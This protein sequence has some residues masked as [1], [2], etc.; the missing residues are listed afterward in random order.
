[1]IGPTFDL[2]AHL[3]RQMAFS[4]KTFGPGKRVCGVAD[5]CGLAAGHDG[6]HMAPCRRHHGCVVIWSETE[7]CQ[8]RDGERRAVASVRRLG[9]RTR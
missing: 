9:E 5:H 3:R 7:V 6:E 2:V 4:A 8:Q 1:M